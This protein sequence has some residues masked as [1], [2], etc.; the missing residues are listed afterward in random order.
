M[1]IR[2]LDEILDA[3]TEN[4]DGTVTLRGISGQRVFVRAVFDAELTPAG[5]VANPESI[6][7]CLPTL[8][9]CLDA[10]ARVIL[11]A[12]YLSDH[13]E[14]P[15]QGENAHQPSL[16][17]I[18]AFLA[19]RLGRDVKLTD[20]PTGDGVR[21]VISDMREGELVVL[22]NLNNHPGEAANDPTFARALA[23]QADVYVNEAFALANRPLAS[24]DKLAQLVPDRAIGLRF[25]K[26]V[27]ELQNLKVDVARP[28]VV[29]L[30][31][32]DVKGTIDFID[33]TSGRV[34]AV[35]LGGSVACTF[36]A[37]QGHDVNPDQVQ[38]ALIPSVRSLIRKLKTSKTQLVLPSDILAVPGALQRERLHLQ[39][40]NS[41]FHQSTWPATSPSQTSDP[42]PKR[43]TRP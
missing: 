34:D 16:M 12:S 37:A 8:R 19:E 2:F 6:E 35:C 18:A 30:G 26:E 14:A 43:P 3:T 24:V 42:R 31:G 21:K 5:G 33:R 38:Q 41:P 20:E 40:P 22:E 29:L 11:G 10:G 25:Q 13:S 1:P 9:R 15:D 23:G 17:P 36:L 7:A 39:F 28:W 32:D 4:P 27:E